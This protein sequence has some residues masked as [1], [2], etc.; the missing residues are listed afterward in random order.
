[1]K[2]RITLRHAVAVFIA[3]VVLSSVPA[4]AILKKGDTAPPINVVTT[5]GQHVTLANYRGHVLV[6]DFFASWCVPCRQSVP[7]LANL[8]RKYG[9]QGLQILGMSVDDDG[10]ELKAFISGTKPN[11]PVTMVNEALQT[12]Y[13]LRS[14]P[15]I[16]VISKKGIVAEKF[17]GY[18]D[19]VGQSL[20]SAIKRLLA[21]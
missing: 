8:N 7:H 16:Y 4:F 6:M 3:V 13:G 20:E 14:V 15:T 5:S 9:K 1:M 21:E 17:Q 19:Q 11:Y 12:D 18:S 2:P 10:D